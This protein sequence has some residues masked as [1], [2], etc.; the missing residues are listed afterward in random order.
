[1]DSGTYPPTVFQSDWRSRVRLSETAQTVLLLASILILAACLRFFD[2]GKASFWFEELVAVEQSTGM[3]LAHERLPAGRFIDSPHAATA[4]NGAAP[5]WNIWYSAEDGGQPPLHFILLRAW[6][7]IFG[8]GDIAARALSAALSIVTVA[9]LFFTAETLHGRTAALWACLIMAVAGPQIE[10]SQEARSYA[11]LA[12]LT[13]A[14]A[15]VLVRIEKKGTSPLRLLA[16]GLCTLAAL[17]THYVAATALMAALCYAGLRLRGRGRIRVVV[18][19]LLA[20]LAFLTTWGPFLLAQKPLVYLLTLPD[21]ASP[22]QATSTVVLQWMMLPGRLFAGGSLAP[23]SI[24]LL[25]AVLYVMPLAMARRRPDLLLWS[26]W[27]LAMTIPLVVIDAICSASTLRLMRY[28]LPAAPAVY[29][30]AAALLVHER[31][32]RRHIVPIVLTVSCLLSLPSAYTR[33]KE[34]W[35]GFARYVAARCQPGDVLVLYRKDDRDTHADALYLALSHYLPHGEN[36]ENGTSEAGDF[37]VPVVILRGQVPYPLLEKIN[38]ARR[39][40]LINPDMTTVAGTVFP[41]GTV[42]DLRSF[43]IFPY[44]ATIVRIQ[45]TPLGIPFIR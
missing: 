13:L 7:A 15:A 29:C 10:Y 24:A 38:T 33:W 36:A 23:E 14:M 42:S 17:L 28:T 4:L 20:A 22:H 39:V 31:G 32:Y 8:E 41:G 26:I 45:P 19:L 11:M 16:I 25:A 12:A 6:R 5:W 34:D 3:G 9:L 27:L 1:M 35:R 2:I 43:P 37:L 18:T 40:W 44:P 30:I 21:V